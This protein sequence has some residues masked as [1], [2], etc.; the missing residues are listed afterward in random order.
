MG[1]FRWTVEDNRLLI[2]QTIADL[3]PNKG[4]G[5]NPDVVAVVGFK[6]VV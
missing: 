5:G 6:G 3:V 1:L 4:H 2:G